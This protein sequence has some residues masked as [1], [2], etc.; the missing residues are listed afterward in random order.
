MTKPGFRSVAVGGQLGNLEYLIDDAVALQYRLLAG[1]SADYVNLIADDC[2]SMAAARF[3]DVDLTVVWRSFEFLRPPIPG[4]RVQAGGWLREVGERQGAPW[5][6]VSAFAVDEIGTEILRSEAAFVVG[7]PIPEPGRIIADCHA[8]SPSVDFAASGFNAV[9]G[10]S[11]SLGNWVV[12]TGAVLDEYRQ[13]HGALSSAPEQPT[14]NSTA[15]LLA[16]W[17]EGRVGRL[18]GDD[19]RWGGRLS[20]AYQAPIMPGDELT[21]DA[22]VIDSREDHNGT[23]IVNLILGAY[24]QRNEL[25]ASG[26]ASATMPSPRLI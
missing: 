2:T 3:G 18:L 21:A 24:N 26:T 7:Y 23:R 4:R 20:L 25:V 8:R 14:G 12:P 15:Q 17:L 1:E 10:D 5:L 16:G 6:R 22:V 13:R 9:V 19:F 11:L